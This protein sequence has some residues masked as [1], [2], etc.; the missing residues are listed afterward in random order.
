MM[1]N[2]SELPSSVKKSFSTSKQLQHGKKWLLGFFCDLSEA[3]AT[4]VA[5]DCLKSVSARVAAKPLWKKRSYNWF[6]IL[7]D[8]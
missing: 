3:A 1:T 8:G 4:Q 6:M 2:N 5:D 7:S